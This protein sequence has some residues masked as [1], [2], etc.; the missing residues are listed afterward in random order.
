M[1]SQESKK[2]V[3]L[4][5]TRQGNIKWENWWVE[6]H[7]HTRTKIPGREDHISFANVDLKHNRCP[8]IVLQGECLIIQNIPERRLPVVKQIIEYHGFEIVSVS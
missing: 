1:F 3:E 8:T 7:G 5:W 6:Q 4:V 2:T